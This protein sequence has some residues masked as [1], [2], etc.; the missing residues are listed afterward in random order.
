MS[1]DSNLKHYS[2]LFI[3]LAPFIVDLAQFAVIWPPTNA[4]LARTNPAFRWPL[5]ELWPFPTQ[6]NIFRLASHFE[7]GRGKSPYDP[8][9]LSA[10]LLIGEFDLRLD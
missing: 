9:M 7:N 6:D 8:K 10:S 4:P 2:Q 5:F 1:S 3:Y